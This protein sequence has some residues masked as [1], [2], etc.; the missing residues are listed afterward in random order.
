VHE[1]FDQG[2]TD[3]LSTLIVDENPDLPT[4]NHLFDRDGM[5]VKYNYLSWTKSNRLKTESIMDTGTVI[6][7][8]VLYFPRSRHSSFAIRLAL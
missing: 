3:V 4:M 7:V 2:G 5:T 1:T 8:L 6:E